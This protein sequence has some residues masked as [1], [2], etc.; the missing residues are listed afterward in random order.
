MR[1]A[2]IV[3]GG[4]A[5]FQLALLRRS[6]GDLMV[7]INTPL[8]TIAFIAITR[9]A[10]RADLESYAVLAPVLMALWLMAVMVCGDIVDTERANGT[11]ELLLGSPANLATVVLGRVLTVTAL[12]LVS[13]AEVAV[14]AAAFGVDLAVGHGVLFAATLVC[15]ALATAGW[16]TALTGLFVA[17]RSARVFQNGMS[18]PVYVLGG[19]FVPVALLPDWLRPLTAVVYLSWTSELLRDA[20]GAAPVDDVAARLLVILALGS[21]GFA[22]GRWLLR[23]V[24]TRVRVSGSAGLA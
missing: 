23:M 5:R 12:S 16:A 20:M 10:G 15:G 2:L 22:V 18:Y 11:L 24:V 14:V 6:P 19:A 17:A 8:L 4:A 13:V 21:C 7:L 3:L 9:H 1:T